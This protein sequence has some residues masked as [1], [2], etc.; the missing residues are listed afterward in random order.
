M[1][2]TNEALKPHIAEYR[3]KKEEERIR[4]EREEKEAEEKR[5]REEEEQNKQAKIRARWDSGT[6]AFVADFS[7]LPRPISHLKV[8]ITEEDDARQRERMLYYANVQKKDS[9]NTIRNY[10]QIQQIVTNS[11]NNDSFNPSVFQELE[12]ISIEDNC[13]RRINGFT[14]SDLRKLKKLSVGSNCC[15]ICET[16]PT[17]ARA[18]TLRISDCG[19][20]ESIVIGPKSF[21]DWGRLYIGSED[22]K[23]WLWLDLP[24]LTEL[25]MGAECFNRCYDAVFESNE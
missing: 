16:T 4:K 7:F 9:R 2:E 15:C 22:E 5:K 24:Q 6:V 3:R 11:W 17:T 12:S 23:G 18:V 1:F 13:L 21:S 10:Y 25:K 14:V 19:C 20:L 8:N